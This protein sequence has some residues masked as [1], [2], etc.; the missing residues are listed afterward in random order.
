M[1]LS[2]M[3]RIEVYNEIFKAISK[4]VQENSCNQSANR[5]GHD[6]YVFCK[7]N[8]NRFFTE[9]ETFRKSLAPFHEKEATKI[10]LEG[11][12]AYK[13]GVYFWLD[14]LNEKCEIVDQMKYQI[15]VKGKETSYQLINQA[16]R[17]AC[18][19]IKSAHSVHKM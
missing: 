12:D 2:I 8:V 15:G 7:N 17:E 6:T 3:Q 11:L 16:C 5:R 10:L 1:I 19:G 14:A 13:E 18:E 4:E 9:E